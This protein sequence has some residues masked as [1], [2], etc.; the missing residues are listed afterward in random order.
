MSNYNPFDSEDY[1]AT[2]DNIDDIRFNEYWYIAVFRGDYSKSDTPVYAVKVKSKLG[3]QVEKSFLYYDFVFQFAK[4]VKPVLGSIG[5][6][7]S[8]II[9]H[10]QASADACVQNDKPGNKN[11]PIIVLDDQGAIDILLNGVIANNVIDKY[12]NTLLENIVANADTFASRT[13]KDADSTTVAAWLD[14]DLY[15]S[16]SKYG[17]EVLAV[18]DTE[19]K[20]LIGWSESDGIYVKTVVNEF[21]TAGYILPGS[22]AMVCKDITLS[23]EEKSFRCY[24]I[25]ISRKMLKI[26]QEK[27][28]GEDNE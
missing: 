22:G 9:K 2:L 28:D 19:F 24:V 4:K 7:D 25:D 6:L 13:N 16:K 5:Y 21:I 3:A 8:K 17:R 14:D 20:K 23:A 27:N 12:Y 11:N 15:T 18:R 1:L 26:A 10:L